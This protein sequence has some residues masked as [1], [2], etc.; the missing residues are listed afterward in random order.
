MT[1]TSSPPPPPSHVPSPAPDGPAPGKSWQ[2]FWAGGQFVL[3]LAVTVGFLVYLL[4]GPQSDASSAA[5]PPAPAE[6]IATV[7]G[8]GL[9]RVQPGSPF[10]EKIH[11][12]VVTNATLSAPI[13]AVTGRVAAS[14]RPGPAGQED[15]WQFDSP[16]MLTAYTDW[17]KA[18]SDISFSETQLSLTRQLVDQRED[19]QRKVVARLEKLVAAGT[20]T[21]KDLAVEQTNLM[22]GQVEGRKSI[23]EAETALR[24]ARRNEAALSRQLQQSGL[25]PALL[26]SVTS[27]VDIVMADVPEGRIDQVQVGQS[28]RATFFG[29]PRQPFSGKVNSIAPVLSKERRSLRVLFVVDDPHDSLRPGMFAEIGLGTDPRDTLL[30]PAD[31]VLHIGRADY[32]L[33]ESGPGDWRVAEVRVGEPHNG[34]VEILDGVSEGTKVIGKGAI[35]FKPLVIRALQEVSVKGTG[36]SGTDEAGAGARAT[37]GQGSRP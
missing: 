17:Q 11:I 35:L 1:N 37:T 10:D 27:D 7:V 19:A 6:N 5:A 22:Q 30:A 12:A 24:I 4:R 25:E 33:I 9:I 21:V 16:E 3:A 23:H 26:R 36:T 29:L 15:F 2:R 8:P 20:D 32:M 14:L 31:G 18:Q 13:M 34:N 28:C